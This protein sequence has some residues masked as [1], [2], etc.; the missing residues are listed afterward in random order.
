MIE[1]ASITS[2]DAG[3]L[4]AGSPI[5]GHAQGEQEFV[6]AMLDIL[7]IIGPEQPFIWKVGNEPEQ[8][9]RF[10]NVVKAY[11]E[12]GHIT[13]EQVENSW[14]TSKLLASLRSRPADLN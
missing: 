1:F 5:L 12:S 7:P 3:P 2:V 9:A 11:V 13:L 8:V 14:N 10:G 4:R 6:E